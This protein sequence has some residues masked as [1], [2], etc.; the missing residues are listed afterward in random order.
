MRI[1]IIQP[2]IRL[3]GAELVSINLATAL[4]SRGNE[5]AITCTYLDLDGMPKHAKD[6]DYLLPSRRISMLIEQSRLLFLLAGPWVLLWLVW[7]HS[8]DVD[9]LNS[10]EFPSTWVATLIGAIRRIPVV[11]SSYGPT[12]RFAFG[13]VPIIGVLDWFGWLIASSWLDRI[14]VRDVAAIH[15]PSDLSRNLIMERYG[16]S[17][18]VIGLG[19]DSKFYGAGSA[20]RAK[21]KYGLDNKFVLLCVGK[22]HP[23]ENQ[24]ICLQ[25]LKFILPSVP[26]A[27]V[28][29]AGDGP[30]SSYLQQL[31]RN[32]GLLENVDFLGQVSSWE[33]RDLFK[34]CALHLYPPVNES[35][36]LAPIEAL[37]AERLSIL[38]NDCGASEVIAA[39]EIGVVCDPTAQAF[40]SHIL[41]AHQNPSK[42]RRMAKNGKKYVERVLTWQIHA[43]NVES[44]LSEFTKTEI[45]SHP[46]PALDRGFEP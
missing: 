45:E 10:H 16:R 37:C 22:L 24:I 18:S 12:R 40:A 38:S 8:R 13:Q 7:R 31:A 20:E 28:I 32:W 26:N 41:E 35:W 30:M 29:F 6:L 3:G 9:V 46:L 5:V 34:A 17:A 42:V 1:L 21:E 36:G 23:Q 44:L 15:V 2:W 19:V 33:I 43:E 14:I 27:F 11:W 39:E 25:A 4:K